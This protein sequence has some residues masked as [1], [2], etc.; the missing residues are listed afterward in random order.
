MSPSSPFCS[1]PSATF[2]VPIPFTS[3]L[4]CCQSLSAALLTMMPD[5]RTIFPPCSSLW[6]SPEERK[7]VFYISTA[8]SKCK[9]MW[10]LKK[11]LISWHRCSVCVMSAVPCNRGAVLTG[12]SAFCFY[13][14]RSSSLFTR[15]QAR[16]PKTHS[17][18][19]K[20]TFFYL[21][22]DSH[23]LKKKI[24]WHFL[25]WFKLVVPYFNPLKM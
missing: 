17:F 6:A 18:K 14:I 7:S 15:P 21:R 1:F 12:S 10:C 24:S 20:C 4:K 13:H 5:L 25:F 8:S 9:D 11:Y 19:N 16:L 2:R 3:Q 22:N 23:E